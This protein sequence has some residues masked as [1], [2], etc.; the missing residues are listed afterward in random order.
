MVAR[1]LVIALVFW[2]AV[3][4]VAYA[5]VKYGLPEYYAWKE[6]KAELELE[7]ERARR[8]RTEMLVDEAEDDEK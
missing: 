8:E 7:R 1:V 2:G 6:R 5:V 4:L 3:G